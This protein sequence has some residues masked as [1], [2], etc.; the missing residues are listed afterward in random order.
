M[1]LEVC[2]ALPCTTGEYGAALRGTLE[3]GANSVRCLVGL[4]LV[5]AEAHTM[6]GQ[7]ERPEVSAQG[8]S[9]RSVAGCSRPLPSED[10]AVKWSLCLPLYPVG[11]RPRPWDLP[12]DPGAWVPALGWLT[13][14]QATFQGH[15]PQGCCRHLS[16]CIA[17][18]QQLGW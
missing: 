3:R 1:Y 4:E 2:T 7:L 18:A 15:C 9:Y 10:P 14:D 16:C 5:R 6:P 13:L 17:G 12:H 8:G 11:L